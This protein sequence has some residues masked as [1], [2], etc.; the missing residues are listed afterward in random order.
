MEK[1][2]TTSE[3]RLG[4]YVYGQSE[5]EETGEMINHLCTVRCLDNIDAAE[6]PIMVESESNREWFDGFIGIELTEDIL[7]KGG[8]KYRNEHRGLGA[9]LDFE[10]ENF[11]NWKYNLSVAFQHETDKKEIIYLHFL[12]HKTTNHIKYVHQLQNL[13]YAFTGVELKFNLTALDELKKSE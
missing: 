4:N 11:D 5:S 13:Y 7:L 1:N 6:Y 10:N 12:Q 2:L 9:I 8:F 3:L